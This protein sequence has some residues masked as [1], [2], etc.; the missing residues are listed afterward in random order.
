MS[1]PNYSAPSAKVVQEAVAEIMDAMVRFALVL[2]EHV[3]PRDEDM[4]PRGPHHI[5]EHERGGTH[6]LCGTERYPCSPTCTHDD[7]ATPGHPER[8]KERSEVFSTATG[9]DYGG[10]IREEHEE[11]ECGA[12]QEQEESDL[13]PVQRGPHPRNLHE[14]AY[15]DGAEDMR[16]ACL[17]DVL[18]VLAVLGVDDRYVVG[19]L[20]SAIEGAVP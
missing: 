6:P 9:G 8:V 2:Q 3:L 1:P 4:C 20:K 15:D 10:E 13:Q 12:I 14:E 16:A 7:A 18:V 11:P 17:R 5:A 19:R